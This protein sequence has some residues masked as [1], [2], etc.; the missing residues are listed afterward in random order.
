MAHI[1]LTIAALNT[2]GWATPQPLPQGEANTGF[3]LS[4]D[5][6]K[7]WIKAYSSKAYVADLTSEENDEMTYECSSDTH[8]DIPALMQRFTQ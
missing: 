5:Y 1:V 2:K 6:R 8:L 7:F 3:V 4:S